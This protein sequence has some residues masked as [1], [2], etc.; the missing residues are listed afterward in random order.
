MVKN[1]RLTANC[2]EKGPPCEK[3]KEDARVGEPFSAYGL[4]QV[5]TS[6]GEVQRFH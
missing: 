2:S 6:D 3:G 5:T 4:R 1:L